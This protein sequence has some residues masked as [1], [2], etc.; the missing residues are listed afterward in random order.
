VFKTGDKVLLS[1]KNLQLRNLSKK[2]IA[3]FIGP[4]PIKELIGTQAYQLT[5][6]NNLPIHLV[7][8]TSLLRP[9]YYREGELD[10]LPG[11]IELDDSK[12]TGDCY[13]VEA[14]VGKKKKK[15]LI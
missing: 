6:P 13:E 11:P 3:R 15:R 4:F 2:L 12:E 8:Y 9:Y 14:L 1:A 7:F 5:L 10:I